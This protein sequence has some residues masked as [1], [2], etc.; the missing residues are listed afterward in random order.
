VS[1]GDLVFIGDVHL[2]RDDPALEDFL[3]FLRSLGATT[4]R[5]VLLGDLFNVWIGGAAMEQPHQRAV[6]QA[7]AELRRGGV[8]V[9]Y[10][11]GNRD[12]RIGRH[13]TGTALDEASESHL[14]ERHGGKSVYTTHGDLVNLRDRQYRAWRAF[15]RSS[16]VW[17]LFELLPVPRRLALVER[18]ERRMRGTNLAQKRELPEALLREFAAARLREGHDAVVLGHFHVEREIPIA[19][20]GAAGRLFV[21]PEWRASRRHLVLRESG[22]LAFVDSVRS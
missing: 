22:E 7:L 21:L 10:L 9:G 18:L 17:A 14:I 3:R 1:E 5:V 20:P 8:R 2:D 4:S 15:S 12:Y 13:Y 19:A 6:A 11:E 16:P